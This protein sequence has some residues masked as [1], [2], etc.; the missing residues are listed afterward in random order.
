VNLFTNIIFYFVLF[1]V[2]FRGIVK[3]FTN[4]D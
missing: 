1:G 4:N 3:N 2:Y